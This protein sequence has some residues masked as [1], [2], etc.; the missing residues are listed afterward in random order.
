MFDLA[1]ERLAGRESDQS[2]YEGRAVIQAPRERVFDAIG[3][4][5]GVRGWWTELASGSAEPGGELRLRFKGLDEGIRM[6]VDVAHRPSTVHWSCREHTMHPEWVGTRLTFDTVELGAEECELRF[7][8]IGLVPELECYGVCSRGWDF[9]L[10][11]IAD[12]AEYG[13]GTPYGV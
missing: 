8:H 9:F 10:P 1:A 12:Y 11:S 4:L 3:T 6:H 5:E 13:H 2:G 7:R